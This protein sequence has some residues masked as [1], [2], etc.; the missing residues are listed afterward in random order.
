MID[1]DIKEPRLREAV[2]DRA[3]IDVLRLRQRM[4]HHDITEAEKIEWTSAALPAFIAA[5]Q[6]LSREEWPGHV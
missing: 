5:E 1:R 2:I 4:A 3:L 6:Q